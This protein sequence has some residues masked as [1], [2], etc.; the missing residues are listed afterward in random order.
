MEEN[1]CGGVQCLWRTSDKLGRQTA[2]PTPF[3]DNGKGEDCK[4]NSCMEAENI[5][6]H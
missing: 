5:S 2:L 1:K 4:E 3:K 6:T